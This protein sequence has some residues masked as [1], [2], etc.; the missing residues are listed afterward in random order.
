MHSLLIVIPAHNEQKTIADIV[1]RSK[2]AVSADVLV[3]DDAST[4]NTAALASESGAIV[5]GHLRCMGAW[6][7]MQTGFLYACQNR[8]EHIVTIDADG[9]HHPEVIR[10]LLA[11][12]SS[13]YEVVIGSNPQRVSLA[14]KVAWAVLR[15]VSGLPVTD[16]TSGLRVYSA[17]SLQLMLSRGSSLLEFQDLGV[18][19]LLNQNGFKLK[20]IDV[21]MSSRSDG[22]SRIFYSWLKVF[23]YMLSTFLLCVAKI[24][25]KSRLGSTAK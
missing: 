17:A 9:Q 15:K 20:E 8:Y 1:S 23:D 14:R 4:D 12:V 3:V 19:M 13:D 10:Q 22:K 16:L 18:L 6:R 25:L 5:V 7:A 11:T 2:A 24:D 21:P